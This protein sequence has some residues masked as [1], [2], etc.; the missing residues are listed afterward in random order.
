MLLQQKHERIDKKIK[1]S[2]SHVFLETN[3]R[4]VERAEYLHTQSI[5]EG[6]PPTNL[7]SIIRIRVHVHLLGFRTVN[8]TL[9]L[10][11]KQ[12]RSYYCKWNA[13]LLENSADNRVWS[14]KST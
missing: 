13:T 12:E 4:Y 2:F 10:F 1:L 11:I 6:G 9:V 3:R 14:W 8:L 7:A 5:Q